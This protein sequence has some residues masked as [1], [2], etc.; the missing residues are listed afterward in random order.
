[1]EAAAGVVSWA[2]SVGFDIKGKTVLEVGTGHMVDLPTGLW[3]CGAERVITVDLNPYLSRSLVAKA[4]SIVRKNADRVVKMFGGEDDQQFRKR[5]AILIGTKVPDDRLLSEMNIDYIAPADAAN[6]SLP[7]ESVDLHVSHTVMEHIPPDVIS[8]ILREAKRVLRRGGLLIHNI[9]PSDHF[10]HDDP[11]I[12]RIN[13]LRFTEAE[14]N[15]WAGN[16]FMYH[17]RL[18]AS[19][20][21]RLFEDSGA[22]ILKQERS[23]DARSKADLDNGFPLHDP[24]KG[25]DKTELA[26]TTISIMAR[27]D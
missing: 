11:S 1:M 21:V 9:D 24:F 19:D 13:F 15:K 27:F 23:V 12:S 5:L 6:L 16:R 8:A 4:R 26:T 20:Y 14:W 18:R 22:N 25:I 10:A 3:L 17:N 7:A 2:Q